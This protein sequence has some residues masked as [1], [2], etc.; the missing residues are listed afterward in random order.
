MQTIFN[1]T[2]PASQNPISLHFQ[3]VTGFS[4]LTSMTSLKLFLLFL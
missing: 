4:E 1:E 3:F 2:Q